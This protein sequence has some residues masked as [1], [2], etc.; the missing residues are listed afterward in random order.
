MI[1]DFVENA[2]NYFGISAPLDEGLKTVLS[3][4]FS[5]LKAGRQKAPESDVFFTVL[6]PA[7]RPLAQTKWERHEQ[8]IDIQFALADGEHIGCLPVR[9]IGNWEP[10]DLQK[11]IA[12]AADDRAGCVLTMKP[13]MFAV[14]FPSD[15]HRPCIAAPV[16]E[17]ARKVVVKVPAR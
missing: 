15:A 8:Y 17:S 10:M 6:E 7:L 5:V 12:F 11:D 14:F 13:G 3:T 16:A 4:D 2:P 9:E 1:F